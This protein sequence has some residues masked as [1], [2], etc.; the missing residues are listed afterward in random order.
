[1][2]DAHLSQSH[3]FPKTLIPKAEVQTARPIPYCKARD[4]TGQGD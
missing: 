2:K 3:D 4:P 1:M